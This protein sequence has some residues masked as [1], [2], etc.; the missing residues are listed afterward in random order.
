[1]ILKDKQQAKVLEQ[2]KR[3]VKTEDVASE[4][5]RE[6]QARLEKE[7]NDRRLLRQIGEL[8][9]QKREFDTALE[10]FAQ[11][12]TIEGQSDPGLEKAI[13]QTKVRRLDHMIAQLDPAADDFEAR[14]TALQAEREEL[15][16]N[17]AKRLVAAYP[18]DLSHRFDL[19]VLLFKAG[20]IG[21]AI[22]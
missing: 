12:S 2:E 15:Q 5:I 14:K 10:Y 3:E 8:Y 19:G 16:I 1:D 21:E 4:L 13:I 6:Y 17:E 20:R 18:N 7:P 9:A 22:P 11:I